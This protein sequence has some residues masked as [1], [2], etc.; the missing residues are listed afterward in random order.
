M[1]H[2]FPNLRPTPLPPILSHGIACVR[3][4]D[5][6]ATKRYQSTIDDLCG[7]SAA[8]KGYFGDDGMRRTF[9]ALVCLV[10]CTAAVRCQS[11]NASLSGR[12]SDPAK[13]RIVNARIAATN[14]R[15]NFCYETT[16]NASGEYLLANLP[17]S[18]YH[19]EVD[20]PGFKTLVRPDVIIYVQDALVIDFW[21]TLG[22]ASETITVEAGAPLLDTS[23]ASVSTLV[24]N[25]FVENM[26]LNGRSFSSLI[27][28][29]P[30]VVLTP[31]NQYEEG[32]F[33]V[34]G[35]RPDA[36]YFSVDGVSA[37]LGS[38]SGNFGQGGAGQLPATSAF[39]GTSNLVS[40]DALQE[41]R[42]QT[43]TF[44]PEYG[45]TP[46]AQVSVVTKSGTNTFHGTAFEYFRNDVLDAN[47]W[48]A[49]NA[50]LKKPELRQNDFGGVLGGPII[51]DKLFFFGSFEGLRVRQPLIANTYVPT[52][53]T[54]QS[55]PVAVQPLLNAFPK[56]T[57]G[58]QDFGNGTAA[59]VAGYSDP[60]TLDSYGIRV[61]YLPSQR[62]TFF[63]RYNDAPS[64]IAQH[65]GGHY[66]TE[67]SNLLHTQNR[68]QSLTLASNQ[69]ITTTLSNEL[70]FNYSQSRGQSFLT[71]D[72]FGG[73]VPTPD[74]AI[75]PPFASSNNGFFAFLGDFNPYGLSFYVG[76]IADNLQ[77]QINITDNLSKIIGSHQLKFG[78]DYR[79]LRP[80]EG[81]LSYE[82][83]YDFGSLASVLANSAPAA[84]V[85]SRTADVQLIISNWSLFAQDTWNLTHNV[86]M[87]YGLRWE[88]NP[89]PSSPNGTL[90]FTV[91]G[92]DN[93][94]TVQ[95]AP[96]GTALW[97]PQKHDFAPR[98]AVAWHARPNLVLRFGAGFF[99]DLGY[100]AVTDGMT[101]F[102]YV[103]DNVLFGVSF[104]LSSTAAAPPPFTTS[105]PS[106]YT[107]VVDPNH[108]LPRTYEWNGSVEQALGKA[109][110]LTLT[111]LGAGGRKLMRQDLYNAPN[112][113]QF[114]GEFDLMRNGATSSYNALQAQFRHHLAHGLQ[115]LISYTWAH[116]IDDVS[117]DVYFVNVP[118]GVEP[119]GQD[120]GPSDYDIRQTFAG[121]V[122]YD[123]PAAGSGIWKSILGHW[124]ADSIIYARSAIPVNVVTG[125]DPFNTVFLSGAMGIARPNVVPGLPFY[126]DES[127]AP[128]GKVID[129]AA[130]SIPATGQGDL[131][132]NA[133]RGFG[134]TQIDLTLRRQF[135]LTERISL[136]ARGDLFNILNHPNFGAPQNYLTAGGQPNPLF[137]QATQTLATYLGSG[138]QG[139]GLNPLYQIGGP[140]SI[141]LALK[142][143]F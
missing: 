33:S 42:I 94:A 12:V 138:G 80:Q 92:L 39:G 79:R 6:R 35:Q 16:T 28:L 75:F 117:S 91:T 90:P 129:A 98:L 115:T 69:I 111:Y 140:R 136:Q 38:G 113:A 105:P 107:A 57:P 123:I 26:P 121:A 55:A 116:S 18:T 20:K 109:D 101:A 106:S 78:L 141:Q 89:A 62:V 5:A 84:L 52:V 120:R 64:N 7:V 83:D 9:L 36:N 19:I 108:V 66:Q 139:G 32:Q 29:A 34:N 41:F 96:P 70:R 95:L 58:G 63:G 71:L 126:L 24:G 135:R 72:S 54:I 128:G 21:M 53:A 1:P 46:G 30:G 142:L 43:S 118:P 130:F 99:Y 68:F 15:T 104:P 48:F 85:S 87:T 119:P 73:A 4:S 37:N 22:A 14:I 56:P 81:A 127:T 65:A 100:S 134:A 2:S 74:S 17:P 125:D 60:S 133:L 47:D 132:R 88:Y 82:L 103:Q 59:F 31:A 23:D 11:T 143:V 8:S 112:P 97:D 13:A 61:D 51:K 77:Q 50:G 124:S 110:V 93:L 137:G 114:T 44:A 27:D 10:L 86:T 67:Y 40:L 76:K 25:Q 3:A 131:G 49:D 45:R 122:S 102:P